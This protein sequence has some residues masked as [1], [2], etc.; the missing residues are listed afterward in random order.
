MNKKDAR[1]IY[2]RSAYGEMASLGKGLHTLSAFMVAKCGEPLPFLATRSKC[3]NLPLNVLNVL[4]IMLGQVT[5]CRSLLQMCVLL[6]NE[7]QHNTEL[8]KC[9]CICPQ[10]HCLYIKGEYQWVVPILPK[11]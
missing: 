5:E 3:I 7:Y 2:F 1:N 10:N 4:H 11:W 9:G 8:F 6:H